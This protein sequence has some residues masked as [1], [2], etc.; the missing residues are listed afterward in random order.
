MK[1]SF[2]LSPREVAAHEEVGK[3]RID[4]RPAWGFLII[5]LAI[6]YGVPLHQAWVT[7]PTEPNLSD[8]IADARRHV[9]Q[10]MATPQSPGRRAIAANRALLQSMH[11]FEDELEDE[12][13]VG[14]AIRPWLQYPLSRFGGLGNEQAYIG[15]DGWLFY[16]PGID[17]LTGPGF[18]DPR[19][20]A[21]RRAAGEEWEHPPQPDPRP[22]IIEFHRQL[23]ERDITLI[24]VPTPI[25]PSLYPHYFSR[26]FTAADAPLQNSSYKD[27]VAAMDAAGVL[28]FDPAPILAATAGTD[29]APRYLATDTHWRPEAMEYTA[30]A[31]ADFIREQRPDVAQN[32]HTLH[33]RPQTVTGLGDVALLL[34]RS[35]D[36]PGGGL[37]TVTVHQVMTSDDQFLRTHT[38][39]DILLLG[40]SFSNLYSLESMGWGEAAGF[41]EQV[42]YH[43]R[44]PI[45]RLI[46]NDD[47]AGAT[48]AMLQRELARGRDR[49]AGK[50]VVIW[51]FATRELAVGNWRHTPLRLQTPPPT[52]FWL[53]PAGSAVVRTGRVRAVSAVPRPGTVPYRDHVVA[54]HLVDLPDDEQALVYMLSMQDNQWTPAA[55]LRPGDEIVLRLRPWADVADTYEALNRSE[56]DDIALQLEEPNWGEW[57]DP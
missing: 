44:R 49:L 56:L 47:G 53:A 41:G 45:D 22:A 48:R 38:D 7:T 28:V 42:S 20:L 14:Q 54:V 50:R 34:D 26:R 33:R 10:A 51:Q 13:L 9:E 31:L 4:R 12:W 3:T 57:I 24:L 35:P 8:A 46:R 19:Q 27:W 17:Y 23:A 18:L 15:R 43:L 2:Q 36:R 39:A 6:L 1:P 32:T 21:R 55:R 30:S 37:E 29:S 5:F 16:R 11:R 40:D 52:Q 25:K